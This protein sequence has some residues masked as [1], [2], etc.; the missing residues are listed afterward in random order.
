VYVIQIVGLANGRPIGG[1]KGMYVASYDPDAFGGR[2]EIV[3]TGTLS[4]AKQFPDQAAAFEC[5]RQRST[6]EPSRPDGKPNR[7][8]TA[9]TV[10]MVRV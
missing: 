6:V 7:P 4:A 8:L 2:G 10:E 3:F 1:Y 5:W 9:Y